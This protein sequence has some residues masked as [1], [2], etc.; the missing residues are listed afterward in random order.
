[1]ARNIFNSVKMPGVDTNSFNLDHDV[2]LSF[3]MGELVTTNVIECLPGD[4]FNISCENML[5]MAPMINPVM[6]KVNVQTEYFFVPTRTLWADW[7]K[8]ITGEST[9]EAPFFGIDAVQV[10]SIADYMG[11]PTGSFPTELTISPLAFGAYLK[12]WDEYYRD[13]NLQDELFIPIVPGSNGAYSF[14]ADIP[15]L[16]RAWGKDYF[17]A[18]LPFAQKGSAVQIPL[19][20]QQNILVDYDPDTVAS[21]K[22]VNATT[23]LPLTGSP[24]ASDGSGNLLGGPTSSTIADIDPNGTYSVDVQANA[25]DI[26]TLRRAFRLQEWLERNA[27]GG[28]RYV[29]NILAH[30]G[31]K[32]SDKRLQR[33]EFIGS[34][35]QNMVI[36]EVLATAQSTA[37]GVAVGSMAGHGI[38]VGGGNSF[39]YRC[40]EHGFILGIISVKP[41]TAY[42]QGLHR[43]FT[44]FDR[45]DYAWPTFA[46]LGEQEV[47][48]QELYAFSNF[49]K[50]VFGYV[51]RYAE[52]KYL[53]SRVA[54]EFRTSLDTYHMGRIFE[55]DPSL[56]EE[57]VECNPTTR[58]FSVTEP[59]EDHIWAHVFNNVRAVRKLPRYGIPSI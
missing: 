36:S 46:N 8:W 34:S 51:P 3:S 59:N 12:I 41:Q 45:L 40:E 53:T 6:H 25:T 22:L 42:Q 48:K 39:N 47:L 27:R 26:N 7:E 24:L 18:A 31:I 38:S 49:P 15:P 16:H 56:N 11:L 58:I 14:V 19:V 50:A 44:R 21:Q 57:F 4:S 30:F 32:S 54:G 10:G 52:Y 43:Q 2:K 23:G 55:T 37:D 9:V 5:R 17:T 13:Q 33:P 1:M 20:D 29:E 35:I 28:T